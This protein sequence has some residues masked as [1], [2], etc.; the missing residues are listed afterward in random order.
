MSAAPVPYAGIVTR[1]VALALDAAIV[2]AVL[3]AGAALLAL[4]WSLVSEVELGELGRVIAACA[5]G[6]A[7]AGYFVTFWST[8]GQTPGMRLMDVHVET[9]AGETPGVGRSMVR[10]VGL[11]LAIVPL[12]AGFLPVLL[13]D[14]RRGLHDLL[15]GTVVLHGRL[16]PQPMR[17]AAWAGAGPHPP[18]T[19]ARNIEARVAM[20]DDR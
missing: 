8:V 17:A 18:K 13:D 3:L 6:A 16:A 11:A 5:W 10:V 7:V 1:A 12:F 19:G 15:A 4:V 9:A 2:Q 20:P 14:R